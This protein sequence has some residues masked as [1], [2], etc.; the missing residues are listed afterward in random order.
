MPI[1]IEALRQTEFSGVFYT[2]RVKV[3]KM[4]KIPK[5]YKNKFS[6]PCMTVSI[7]LDKSKKADTNL[8]LKLRKIFNEN[9]EIDLSECGYEGIYRCC[10]H[11]AEVG[12][13]EYIFCREK[14]KKQ[15]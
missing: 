12:K 4:Y 5:R 15:E 13:F 11:G 2:N 3:S 8:D 7:T 1:I 9:S 14:V 10:Q 6:D